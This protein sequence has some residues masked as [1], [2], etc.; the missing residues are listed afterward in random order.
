MR[1]WL[2]V[3]CALGAC[4][5]GRAEPSV[6]GLCVT[7]GAI[8]AEKGGNVIRDPVVRA[9]VPGSDGDRAS[10][11]FTYQGDTEKLVALGSGQ[12]RKQIG[13][14]L[15]AAD[16][17]NLVY[18]M[19]RFEP[20]PGI[21]VSIKSNPGEHTHKQCGT[22]GYQKLAADDPVPVARPSPGETHT[23]AA[24]IRGDRLEATIDGDLV[25]SGTLDATARDLSGPAGLRSDNVE[26][27]IE[28]S[29]QGGGKGA[30]PEHGD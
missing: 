24:A 14:K 26:A 30:C 10:L 16:G 22:D 13:L 23:L 25:W 1:S 11:R 3:A 4:K 28:L 6:A 12:I 5:P 15:R 17:C 7:K 21:E 27:T 19:W 9:V 29:T 8:R 18:V 2:L 20:K